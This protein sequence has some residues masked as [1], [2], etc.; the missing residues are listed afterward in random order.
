MKKEP[1]LQMGYD[2]M[3]PRHI[4]DKPFTVRSLIEVTGKMGFNPIGREH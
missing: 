4:Y 2:R 1:T 3:I